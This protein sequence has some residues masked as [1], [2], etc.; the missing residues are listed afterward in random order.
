MYTAKPDM[1]TPPDQAPSRENYPAC[2]VQ[3]EEK[4]TIPFSCY[5]TCRK[6]SGLFGREGGLYEAMERN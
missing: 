3:M 1:D 5:F 2:L 4:T 6:V